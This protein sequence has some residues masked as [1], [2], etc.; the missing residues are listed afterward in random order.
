MTSTRRY[1]ALLAA[2]LVSASASADDG[3][4]HVSVQ[5]RYRVGQVSGDLQTGK[6]G[7]VGTTSQERPTLEEIGVQLGHEPG[8]EVKAMWRGH[9]V[10]LDASALFLYGDINLR[11]P[12][13]SQDQQ[14]PAGTNVESRTYL[15]LGRAAYRKHL[16]LRLG[17]ECLALRPGGGVSMFRF[18]YQLEGNNGARTDREYGHLTPHLELG[19]AWRPGGT[20]KVWLSADVRQT[21]PWVMPKS[22]QTF[23]FEVVGAVHLDLDPN[24]SLHLEGGWRR[25]TFTDEQPVPNDIDIDFGPWIGFGLTARF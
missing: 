4:L 24:W 8:I 18:H 9:E 3:K 10:N 20:S 14:F 1:L 21:L 25:F 13:V 16:D 5:P 22:N 6:G 19:F 15:L 12:L 7:S 23:Q 17:R 11:D 2:L